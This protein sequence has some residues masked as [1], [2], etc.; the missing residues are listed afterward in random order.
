MKKLNYKALVIF[1]AIPLA[2]GGLAALLTGAGSDFYETIKRPAL[3]PPSWLF[4]V[5]W[6]ILYILMGVSSYMI[7]ERGERGKSALVIYGIQLAVNFAW[8]LVFFNAKAFLAAAIVIVVLW[9]LIA[10]MLGMFYRVRRQAA[11]LQ[12]PY[13]L[14]VTFATYLTW[15]IYYLN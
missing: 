11:Y 3:S 2:V 10:V 6:T 1:I 15:A 4:P 8:S 14:W 9:V 13:F 7:W 5:V 12:I